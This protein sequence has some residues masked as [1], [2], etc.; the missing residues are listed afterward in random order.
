MQGKKQQSQH[1]ID[2]SKEHISQKKLGQTQHRQ[3]AAHLKLLTWDQELVLQL[4][5]SSRYL[6]LRPRHKPRQ[7]PRHI[8]AL[9]KL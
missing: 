6:L 9:K 2:G 5:P 3:P 8:A 7:R 1:A 4:L